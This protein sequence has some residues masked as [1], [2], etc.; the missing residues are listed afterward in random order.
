[1]GIYFCGFLLTVLH[2]PK[3]LVP[4]WLS[5][6][7]L[8]SCCPSRAELTTETQLQLDTAVPW[9]LPPPDHSF[10]NRSLGNTVKTTTHHPLSPVGALEH[11]RTTKPP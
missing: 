11:R 3:T 4:W 6:H 10:A 8:H 7:G 5:A 1:V 9:G 2:L